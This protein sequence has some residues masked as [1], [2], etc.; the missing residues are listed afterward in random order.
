[1]Y[2]SDDAGAS[3]KKMSGFNPRPMYFRPY[4]HRILQD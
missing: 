3:W 4:S 2:R 1:M